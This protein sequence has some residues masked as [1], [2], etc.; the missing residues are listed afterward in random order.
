MNGCG[1]MLR[2][3]FRDDRPTPTDRPTDG[4]TDGQSDSNIDP[5]LGGGGIKMSAID[6][7]YTQKICPVSWKFK[8]EPE[9]CS[10]LFVKTQIRGRTISAEL[11]W[12][13]YVAI[14]LQIRGTQLWNSLLN[15]FFGG[16]CH[17]I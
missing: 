9:I 1:D 17:W 10:E 2:T 7:D 8:T 12:S 4:P 5:H 6:T 13:G 16:K 15:T 11:L 14:C 3:K